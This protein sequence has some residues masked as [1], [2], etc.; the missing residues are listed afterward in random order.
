MWEL[1]CHHTYKLGGLPVDL[2]RY[3]N[4]GRTVGISFLADGIEPGSGAL[5]FTGQGRVEIPIQPVWKTLGGLKLEITARLKGYRPLP[6]FLMRG[7]DSFVFCVWNAELI[8]SYETTQP[9]WPGANHERIGSITDAIQSPVPVY[10]VPFDPW[11]QSVPYGLPLYSGYR[12]PFDRWVTLGFMHNGLDTMEL[13]ADGQLIARRT[14]LLSNVPGV[15]DRG[16]LVGASGYLTSVLD[17]DI[18]EVKVWR[19]DPND[20]A[21]RF[22]SRRMDEAA[23]ECWEK[24]IRC[25]NE[26]LERRPD[27]AQEFQQ[28]LPP[29]IEKFRR[30]IEATG[31]ET[32]E[33]YAMT[34]HRYLQLWQEGALDS[35]AMAK[36][37]S[38]WCTWLKLVGISIEDDPDFRQFL[39]IPCLE[40]ILKECGTLEC[41]P[42]VTALLKSIADACGPRNEPS[43][44]GGENG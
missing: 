17:G 9:V 23:A 1:I 34:R 44:S 41:D 4:H 18:D 29:L 33:R 5:Y 14:D 31:P 40:E 42:Q 7:F 10:Q 13:Y 24:F 3:D 16:V 25:L 43:R 26:S 20:M 39:R 37:M 27:C 19:P 22:L 36:L 32:R 8:A 35:P 11:M 2:S 12:V 38:E 21:R 15:G 28:T 30:A 6:R